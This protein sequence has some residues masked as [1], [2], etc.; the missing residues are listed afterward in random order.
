MTVKFFTK[1]M[2]GVVV[3][4]EVIRDGGNRVYVAV[5]HHGVC[6]REWVRREDV[7]AD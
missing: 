3:S 2:F 4:G 1:Y 5:N 6:W 7:L